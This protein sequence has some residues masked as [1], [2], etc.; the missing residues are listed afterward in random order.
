[1]RCKLFI[2]GNE[3]RKRN[4]RPGDIVEH[5]IRESG[6]F[7]LQRPAVTGRS[8]DCLETHNTRDLVY[9]AVPQRTNIKEKPIFLLVKKKA[10]EEAT[11]TG[12]ES[13]RFQTSK[14]ARGTN[15]CRKY[16]MTPA[17]GYATWTLDKNYIH[18]KLTKNTT[19]HS[20]GGRIPTNVRWDPRKTVE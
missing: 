4:G 18:I 16:G 8:F 14:D 17:F 3:A 7:L 15:W 1:M 20:N 9:P 5:F 2:D 12:V 13:G 10:A 19:R 6:S 11:P